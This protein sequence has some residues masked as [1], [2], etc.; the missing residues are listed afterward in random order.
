MKKP[1]KN[2]AEEFAGNMQMDRSQVAEWGILS[3]SKIPA[4]AE[5]LAEWRSMLVQSPGW[6]ALEET[7]K[8]VTIKLFM[9][10]KAAAFVEANKKSKVVAGAA[11]G[12]GEGG[13]YTFAN[14]RVFRMSLED[15][16]SLPRRY[17]DWG[18]E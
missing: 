9:T 7:E 16:R 13:S 1:R 14:G 8:M 4:N 15:M 3:F 6:C 12:P 10:E 5:R 11:F 2:S 18:F 17:P